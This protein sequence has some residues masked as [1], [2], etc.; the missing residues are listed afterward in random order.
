MLALTLTIFLLVSIFS[1]LPVF[2]QTPSSE[3]FSLESNT[4]SER[5]LDIVFIPEDYTPNGM[6]IFR[7]T[8]ETYYKSLLSVEPFLEFKD[9][10][11]VWR[12]DTTADFQSQRSPTMDRRLTVN[13]TKVTQFVTSLGNFDLNHNYPDDLVIAL[14]NSSV[15]GGSGESDI[16]VSYT[17][18]YGKQVMMHELGHSFG[19][20]GDEYI[21]YDTD[22]PA[23]HPIPFPN[24]D[25]NGSKWQDVPGTGTYLGA[26]YRNLVR[27]TNNNCIMRSDINFA[28]CPVCIRALSTILENYAPTRYYL[29]VVPPIGN[30]EIYVNGTLHTGE[31]IAFTSGDVANITAVPASGWIFKEW[32]NLSL[33]ISAENP[34]YYTM[35]E[36]KSAWAAFEILVVPEFP[37]SSM[38][39]MFVM[40]AVALAAG[41]N[42]KL[43]PRKRIG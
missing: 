21:V 31:D 9:W 42:G 15:Y 19:Q 2:S 40:L 36:N 6:G 27:P 8:V 16:V 18:A 33:P 37:S 20:L 29:E 12:V 34:L 22:L 35:T 1:T 10:I 30:G 23:G 28:F 43:K 41:F 24:I 5:G 11:N 38:L 4:P 13:Y 32:K 7:D 25:W 17:G 14:V 3:L 26:W 39:L